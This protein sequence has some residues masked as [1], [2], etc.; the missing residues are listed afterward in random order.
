[1]KPA[2][3]IVDDDEEIRTQM[4]WALADD[5]ELTLADSRENAVRA[6]KERRPGV[7]LLDLGLPP[8]PNT[9]TEGMAILGEILTEQPTTQVLVITGQADRE[10]AVRAIAA[11]AKDFLPKPVQ[12][13]ELKILLR[14]ASGV[15]DLKQAHRIEAVEPAA[16]GGFAGLV[17]TSPAM[18]KVYNFITKIAATDA[19]VLIL[20]ESGTGK[21]VVASAIHLQSPR[22]EKPF[23][24]I[25]CG[26]IPEALL[27][28]ELFGHEKG[29]FTGAHAQR[30]GRV[31]LAESGTL[32]LDEI[33][34]MPLPLQVK[35]LRFL[36]ERKIERV[37]G[38]VSIS[39]DVRIIAATN[40][41]L[42]RSITAGKFREDLFY[43]L[44]VVNITL[45]PLKDRPGDVQLLAQ[46]FIEQ[47]AREHGRA[48][49][50][51]TLPAQRALEHH[52]WPGNVRE[53][54]NR[55]RRAFIMHEGAS[56]QPED[57][58]LADAAPKEAGK[59]LKEAREE[60]ERSMVLDALRR[61]QGKISHAAAEL[62]V[63][64]P[65]LYELMERLGLKNEE[66]P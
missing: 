32:F 60:L 40:Q 2:V 43:R 33:G 34:E 27:E 52:D 4:R 50:K 62:G 37:G 35:L 47:F 61:N 36:Q 29:S 53:L 63:S 30:K 17:G 13:E 28:S 15:A 3:L 58:E 19:P 64:R 56:I 1:M 22:R 65:T 45:P 5:Y 57:L 10:H 44:N 41:D 9:T 59:P 31:E 18:Q 11:G 8:N 23:V 54:Q 26:A 48:A 46:S 55:V 51:F 20:G 14:R 42:A 66:R 38:R 25:N 39:V 49:P 7:V 21:E 24:A 12:M 6:F 16:G